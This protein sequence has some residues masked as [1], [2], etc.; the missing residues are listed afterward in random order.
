MDT[1]A[2]P[3]ISGKTSA[4]FSCSIWGEAVWVSIVVPQCVHVVHLSR[5][6]WSYVFGSTGRPAGWS[7]WEKIPV[8]RSSLITSRRTFCVLMDSGKNSDIVFLPHH[9]PTSCF[10]AGSRFD[11]P[12]VKQSFVFLPQCRSRVQCVSERLRASVRRRSDSVVLRH[13]LRRP[14]LCHPAWICS[15]QRRPHREPDR[16]AEPTDSCHDVQPGEGKHLV[17]TCCGG[18]SSQIE[19]MWPQWRRKQ[20]NNNMAAL[21]HR[22]RLLK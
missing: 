18:R 2:R 3:S 16:R 7:Y 4:V 12:E 17:Q 10:S 19:E 15:R 14:D 11:L 6:V 13:R 21:W 5:T 20:D 1:E 22:N 8:W 9:H